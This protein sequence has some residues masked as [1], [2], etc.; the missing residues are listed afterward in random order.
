MER[1]IIDSYYIPVTC[2]DS[3][4]DKI[5]TVLWHCWLVRGRTSCLD[6]VDR[7]R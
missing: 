4:T 1:E 5:P 2:A 3:L 6:A 7:S